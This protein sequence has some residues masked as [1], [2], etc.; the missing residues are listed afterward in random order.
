MPLSD[1]EIAQSTKLTPIAEIA[2]KAGL[3]DSEVEFWGHEIS[4]VGYKAL[5]R[6]R[7]KEPGKLILVTAMNPTPQGEGKTTVTI[8]LAQAL[9]RLGKKAMLGIRQPSLGPTMGVK[10]GA[11]GG[12]YSQVLPMEEINLH[13]TGDMY[14]VEA[15][16]NL[17]AAMANND[18]HHGN[19]RHIDPRR[20]RWK[21]VLD[22][23]DRALRNVVVGLGGTS[24][25]MAHESGFEIT[26]ASE[27]MAILCLSQS[28]P[29]LKERLGRIIV[30]YTVMGEPV[31]AKDMGA[32]GAMAAVLKN[33]LKPNLVQSV[34]GVPAFV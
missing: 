21:R 2:S 27:V 6:L 22:M 12:G 32:V 29:D 13:F 26:A 3:L 11:A 9:A 28:I 4:K 33:A 18:M 10:G 34:E 20:V 25:G 23:N 5:E 14:A 7:S 30:A 8:G 1:L 16:H 31:T 24:N 15:A 19:P 17:L